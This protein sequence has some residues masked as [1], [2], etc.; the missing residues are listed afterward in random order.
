MSTEIYFTSNPGDYQK[1]EGVYIT[2]RKPP[3]AIKGVDLS[4]TGIAG[5]AVRGPSTIQICTSPARLIEIYGER[6][7]TAGGAIVSSLWKALQNKKFG[8]V[9]VQRIVAADA[10]LGTRNFSDVV[11]TAIIRVDASSK[12]AWSLSANGG[13]LVSVEA[14]SD[15]VATKFNLRVKYLGKETVYRNLSTNGTDNNL[16]AVI[17]DDVANIITVTKLANGRPLNSADQ[18][19]T[20]GSDGTLV[21][22]DYN[23]AITNLGNYKGLGVVFVAESSVNQTSLNSTIVG[24]APTVSDRLFL[25]WSGT[26]GNPVST[27]IAAQAAQ[28]TTKSDRIIWCFNAAKT[29]D[30]TDGTKMQVCPHEWMASILS[31]TDVDIHPGDYDNAVFTSGIVELANESLTRQDLISLKAAGIATL[32]RLDDGFIFKS[33]VTTSLTSGLEEITR[34][35]MTDFLQLSWAEA[36]KVNVKKKNTAERRKAIM[37]ATVAFS[38]GLKRAGRVIENYEV[39]QDEV[40]TTA[41]RGVGEEHVLWRVRILGHILYFVLDTEI[42]TAIEVAA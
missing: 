8:T 33:G 22:A 10:V 27:E 3:G 2:E 5:T 34:R 38:E 4:R 23:T 16:L 11:P 31:Q 6:S 37:A 14:A 25:T 35:R 13:P 9:A 7:Y 40:N 19:L 18:T 42:G 30:R 28:I 24:L 41:L 12:G 29:L 26:V 36:N 1:L 32:E 17:G 21:A 39:I 15:G 20:G